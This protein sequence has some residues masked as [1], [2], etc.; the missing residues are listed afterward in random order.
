MKDI[1]TVISPLIE[2][3]F[4]DFYKS[5]GPRFID[6]VK[7]YY[8][9]MESQNKAL[10]ASRTLFNTRDIDKTSEDFVYYFQEKYLKGI[11]LSS[12]ANTRLITKHSTDLYHTKGTDRG[13]ELVIRGMFNEEAK[14]YLPGKDVFKTSHGK[15][16]KP[17]YLELT[18]ANRTKDYVGKEIVGNTSGAKAFLESLI[19]RRISGKYIDVAYLSN[20][21]GDFQTDEIITT[22]SN[23]VVSGAP[24]VT[25]SLTELTVITGGADFEVGDLFNIVSSNGKQGKARVTEVSNETGKVSF[26]FVNALASGGWGYN[27]NSTVV[28]SSKVLT[29]SSR[30]NAN[31][32]VTDFFRFETVTQ[33]LANIAY[34]TASPNNQAFVNGAVIENYDG[35]GAVI[36]NATIVAHVNTSLT[37]GY[38]LVS[39]NVGMINVDSTFAVSGNGTTASILTYTD[40]T[41]TGNVTGTNTTHIGVHNV[42]NG[43]VRSNYGPIIGSIS[44]TYG[45]VSNVSTGSTA[46]FKVGTITDTESVFLS[47]DMIKDEN[48]ADVVY[49]NV[50]L[51]GFNANTTTFGSNTIFNGRND[52]N[53][54]TDAIALSSAGNYGANDAVRYYIDTGNTVIGGL[55]SNTVYYIDTSNSTHVT[56]KASKGGTKIELTKSPT[57]ESGHHLVGPLTELT[58]GDIAFKGLGFPKFPGCTVDSILLDVLRFETTTIGSISSLTAINP[59]ADY[60]LDPFV[61]VVEPL[62]AGYDRHDYLM[63]VSMVS[64]SFIYG[65]QIQ[66]SYSTVGTQLTINAMSFGPA[67]N[68]STLTDIVV[69]EFV[70]Q[71]NSTAAV[72]ASGYVQEGS[73]DENGDGSIKL[74]DVTGTFVATPTYP[75][76]TSSSNGAGEAT[77][78]DGITFATTARAIINQEPTTSLLHLKRIN[79]GN[80]FKVGS[81]I[82]GTTTGAVANVVTIDEDLTTVAIGLN[83]NI[84]ANVQTANGVVTGLSVLDSGY[85]YLSQETLTLSSP[86]SVFVVTAVA[87]LGKQGIGEGYYSG[88]QGFLSSSKKLHDNDYYQ[89]Y[90]YEVQTKIPYKLYVDVL[91]QLTHVAGTKMFGRVNSL[92][93]A[94]NEL[95]INST[96]TTST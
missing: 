10:N 33:N 49:P 34:N 40:R 44:N 37:A 82:L 38:I 66:Q 2:S 4:P 85:G 13:A 54:T 72:G 93:I 56:L 55:T 81:T 26:G 16:V 39:P 18:T 41:A 52:V 48:T 83:A 80:S 24:R 30:T 92:S 94:N 74:R 3:Q 7:Q 5:E 57:S 50:L 89:E 87:V 29:L 63:G 53:E 68:G 79:L 71:A 86:D 88:T 31:A 61:A 12:V 96:T 90:S 42:V 45:Y 15:W 91:K 46:S 23:T 77:D 28:V 76:Y 43:F 69:D 21:R 19:R 75:I 47:P 62:V 60:N 8:A 73:I 35:G 58:T 6:F 11:S 27:T 14:I 36:A 70:Y 17:V 22:T 78:V 25:G 32:A 95:T 64:G 65:E 20:V 51:T 59:G 84:T 9:W 1:E 67:A